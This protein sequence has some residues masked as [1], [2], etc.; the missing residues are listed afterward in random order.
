MRYIVILIA[1]FG[2]LIMSTSV[3]AATNKEVWEA[4]AT[5]LKTN[6]QS[7]HSAT[8]LKPGTVLTNGGIQCEVKPEHYVW[9]CVRGHLE[10]STPVAT[11]V[12]RP[13]QPVQTAPAASP[14]IQR[15][16]Y[17]AAAGI[18]QL[19]GPEYAAPKGAVEFVNWE[20]SSQQPPLNQNQVRIVGTTIV[21][22]LVCA[23]ALFVI[24]RTLTKRTQ[25]RRRS[26]SANPLRDTPR[27]V[28][29]GDTIPLEKRYFKTEPAAQAAV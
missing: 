18:S 28:P 29:P 5:Y 15:I 6:G 27:W 9:D 8:R 4:T 2:S 26:E 23:F 16:P 10:K 21:L 20:E 7:W 13:P 1:L 19:S 17:A 24:W 3:H 25:P 22:L 14:R 11:A 12:P